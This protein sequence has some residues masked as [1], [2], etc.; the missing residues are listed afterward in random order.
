MHLL[1]SIRRFNESF[2]IRDSA[3]MLICA[4][5]YENERGRQNATKRMDEDTAKDMVKRIARLL[6]ES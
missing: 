2:I 3:G 1:L 5:Y 6:T 4:V